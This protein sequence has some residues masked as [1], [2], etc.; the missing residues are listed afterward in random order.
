[1]Y[2]S[3]LQ[4]LDEHRR[5]EVQRANGMKMGQLKQELELLMHHDD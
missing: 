2:D 4:D 1:M 3:L 5:G